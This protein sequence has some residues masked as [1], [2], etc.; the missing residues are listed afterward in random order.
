[1]DQFQSTAPNSQL[2]DLAMLAFKKKQ[3]HIHSNQRNLQFQKAQ[4]TPYKT[5]HVFF[6]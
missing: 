6:R 2:S 3:T 5:R 1:M 4:L